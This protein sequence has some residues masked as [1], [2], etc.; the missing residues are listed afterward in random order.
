MVTRKLINAPVK[1]N[2]D[3]APLPPQDMGGFSRALSPYWQPFE[4]PVCGGFAHFVALSWGMWGICRGFV[5]FQDGGGR[6]HKD[7][8]KCSQVFVESVFI[9][10]NTSIN[11]GHG[12]KKAN[13]LIFRCRWRFVSLLRKDK[14]SECCWYNLWNVL[15]KI[16]L[17]IN[18]GDSNPPVLAENLPFLENISDVPFSLNILLVFETLP[19]QKKIMFSLSNQCFC[20]DSLPFL[21]VFLWFLSHFSLLV[22]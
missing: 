10:I 4:S 12:F 5:L 19:S 9:Q 1:V 2:P 7:T 20:H 15:T 17:K 6:S 21:A 11:L 22:S 8:C 16:V 18:C 13:A 14:V 3:P